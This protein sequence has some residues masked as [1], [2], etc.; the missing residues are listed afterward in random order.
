M[1]TGQLTE[2]LASQ[3]TVAALSPESVPFTI[4]CLHAGGT[5]ATVIPSHASVQGLT[6][7]R[8]MAQRKAC[9]VETALFGGA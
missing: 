6:A 7:H 1:E 2:P 4:S 8:M 9:I 3:S 5:A